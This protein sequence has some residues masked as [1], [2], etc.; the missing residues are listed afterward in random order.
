MVSLSGVTPSPWRNG[1]GV[2]RELVAWPHAHDWVWRMSVAQ[3]ARDGPFSRFDGVQR[4]FAVLAGAGV[5]LTADGEC[6]ELGCDSA[7]WSFA[8]EAATACTLVDGATQDFNLMLRRDRVQA[9][10]QRVRGRLQ[11]RLVAPKTIAV[12]AI[13][14]RARACFDYKFFEIPAASLAWRDV[15]AGALVQVDSPNALWMEIAPCP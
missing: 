4:W 7:P 15:P 3:V 8:G 2:T 6:R 10:M 5:R 12:Y 9:S 11:R 14:T 13:D 1:G